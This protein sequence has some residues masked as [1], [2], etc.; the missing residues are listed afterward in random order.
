MYARV[1]IPAG[2][3]VIEYKGERIT[4]AESA[5]LEAQRFERVR[6]GEA[7]STMTFR[8]NQRYDLDPSRHGN[9]SRYINH[10][11]TPNCRAEKKRG[12][13][14]IVAARD[15]AEGEEISASSSGTGPRTPAAAARPS[16]PAIS[17]PKT[18]AGGCGG[19]RR[20]KRTA[21]GGRQTTEGN[22]ENEGGSG[23]GRAENIVPA[24]G[25]AATSQ[26]SWERN[27]VQV[28]EGTEA[29]EITEKRLTA[30]AQRA[31]RSELEP[32]MHTDGH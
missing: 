31:Q 2:Y 24:S 10:S 29:E 32:L 1:A 26:A 8:L 19:G 17:W 25:G 9:I 6:R 21:E 7:C 27:F 5:H 18:S 22:E 28:T 3:V 14:W 13:I 12:H 11:C 23:H 15:I 4:K 20:R 30:G 16:A